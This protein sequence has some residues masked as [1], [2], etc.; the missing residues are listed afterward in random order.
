FGKSDGE[1]ADLVSVMP[2]AR[3][4]ESDGESL[5]LRVQRCRLATIRRADGEA[6]IARRDRAY[7]RRSRREHRRG[8]HRRSSLIEDAS[9]QTGERTGGQIDLAPGRRLLDRVAR[10]TARN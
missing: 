7:G 6:A 8:G 2:H 9:L 10:V 4:C 5:L 1:I 3:R